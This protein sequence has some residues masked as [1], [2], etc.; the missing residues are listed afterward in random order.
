MVWHIGDVI[1]KMR[2][3]RGWS[4]Q[5]LATKARIRPNTLGDLE[6]YGER[7]EQG[8]LASVVRA[9]STTE[10]ALFQAIPGDVSSPVIAA[11]DPNDPDVRAWETLKSL[12][13][14]Q[15]ALVRQMIFGFAALPVTE[16]HLHGD[17]LTHEARP[18]PDIKRIK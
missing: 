11:I 9:L 18:A 12:P 16:T 6:R 15:R 10:A 7:Y 14:G 3:A 5:A 8:T 4:R 13:D 2:E 1:R 17:E